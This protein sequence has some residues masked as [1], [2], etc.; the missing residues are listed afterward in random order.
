MKRASG[1]W[2]APKPLVGQRV[3]EKVLNRHTVVSCPESR[4]VVAVITTAIDDCRDPC[5]RPRR[6]ARRFILG[7]E[8]EAWCDLVGLNVDFVRFVARKAGYLANDARPPKTA[9]TAKA[10]ARLKAVTPTPLSRG[11]SR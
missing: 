11:E 5:T 8:L 2:R 6:A 9:K 10:P 3:L 4:L 1:T 7:P